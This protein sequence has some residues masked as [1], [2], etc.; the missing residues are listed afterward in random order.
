MCGICGFV[1]LNNELGEPEEILENMTGQIVHRGPDDF[2]HWLSPDK[3]VGLGHRRL[4]IHD[5]SSSGHQPMTSHCKRY[6]MIFNGEIYNFKK[7]KDILIEKGHVFIGQSDTEVLVQLI[8]EFGL[9]QSIKQ[10]EGMFA[11]ALYDNEDKSLSFVRDRM[12]E[13][14]LYVGTCGSNIVFGSELKVFKAMPNWQAKI[15]SDAVSRFFDYGYIPGPLSIYQDILKIS[16][17]SILT[18]NTSEMIPVNQWC[19]KKYWSLEE[20]VDTKNTTPIPQSLPEATEKFEALLKNAVQDQLV[21]DVPV[22]IFLS[23]GI[24]SSAVVAMAQACSKD[25]VKTFSIGFDEK[26]FDEIPF[27]N[28]V[29]TTLDTDHTELYCSSKTVKESI[30]KI[31]K[32]Y[33]EPFSDAPQL[34]TMLLC[35]LT[36]KHVT[37]CLSGD[38]GDEL[39]YGYSRYFRTNKNHQKVKSIP[40]PVRFAIKIISS[41]FNPRLLKSAR[42]QKLGLLFERINHLNSP[43]SFYR[44]FISRG[45][46]SQ[47]LVVN[48]SKGEFLFSRPETELEFDHIMR[49]SDTKQYLTDDILVKVDRASMASSLEVRVPLLNH[50]IV[51]FAWSLPNELL[52]S[53]EKGKLPLRALLNK[54]LPNIDFDRPKKGFAVPLDKWLRNDLKDWAYGLLFDNTVLFKDILHVD[55]LA[56]IWEQHQNNKKDYSCELWD[57]IIFI[58][59]LKNENS[60]T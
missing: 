38:G 6:V 56:T 26:E 19:E 17:G 16:P 3:K 8:A 42:F 14:P 4:S 50:K 10:T 45:G 36:R 59:W 39:F 12:G 20:L 23:G 41:I 22:G 25:S 51:E 52:Q 5:L 53:N 24:D 31:I 1:D 27:A 55:V 29:A 46:L 43:W 13:K 7:L 48:K 30:E 35:E 47:C 33:D 9:E 2:G 60:L 54:Y 32:H 57:A 58:L 34:P 28:E 11:L 15:S 37:V 21:A 49:F 44:S 40:S 18:L